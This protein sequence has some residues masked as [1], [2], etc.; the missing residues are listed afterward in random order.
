M[1]Q[2]SEI[3][4]R[5]T[6][7]YRF[8]RGYEQLPWA[9]AVLAFHVFASR[10]FGLAGLPITLAAALAASYA[11][12]RYYDRRFGVVKTDGG[13]P[14]W[15]AI[16]AFVVFMLLQF[17]ANGFRLPVQLGFLALGIAVAIY[18]VRR[19]ELEWQKLFVAVFF[20]GFSVWPVTDPRGPGDDVWQAVFV[21]GFVSAWILMG[22]WD[23]RMLVR[24]FERAR[25]APNGAH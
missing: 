22:V 7:S 25:L 23:H 1:A 18:A 2:D 12:K 14:G 21:Y 20:I 8:L 5:L 19:F 11:I 17:I 4:R 6:R 10:R 13:V 15:L 24:G 3:I 9:L 16:P